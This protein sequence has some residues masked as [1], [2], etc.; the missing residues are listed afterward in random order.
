MSPSATQGRKAY[1][2]AS[3]PADGIGPEVIE[4][5]VEVL[6]ALAEALQSFDLEFTNYNWSSETYKKTGKYIPDG[7]LEGLKKHDAILF[8]AVGAP[9]KQ[10]TLKVPWSLGKA[11]ALTRDGRR[12]RP[13]LPLGSA[14]SHLPA[15]PAVCQC[16][17]HAGPPRHA[18]AAAQLQGRRPRLGYS[19]REQRG[20]VRGPGRSVAPGQGLGDGDRGC[21]LHPVRHQA[22]DALRVR[23]GTVTAAQAADFRHQE[24]RPAQRHGALGRG[25]RRGGHRVPRRDGG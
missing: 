17:S 23:D 14:A 24:Q 15:V 4:A 19:P 16:A 5:G 13:H 9:G 12:A 21:H 3:I 10:P 25:G 11:I 20:R 8:G 6:K 22:A 7:G 2:I 18:V 1:S